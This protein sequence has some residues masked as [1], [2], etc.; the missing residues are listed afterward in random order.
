MVLFQRKLFAP[1]MILLFNFIQ[2]PWN[3]DAFYFNHRNH[4]ARSWRPSFVRQAHSEGAP[5]LSHHSAMKTRNITVSIQFYSLLGFEVEAKFRAGPARAAWLSQPGAPSSNGRLELIE[6]PSHILQE[7]E[8]SKR[9]AFDLMERQELLGWNHLAL[10]VTDSIREKQSAEDYQL[11]D[12]M[13]DLNERSKALFGKSLRVAL[14]PRQQIIGKRVY[15]LAFLYDADGGLI[16]LLHEQSE[17]EQSL[18]SGWEPWN[19]KGTEQG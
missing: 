7:P 3:I 1:V 8:G 19:G 13:Q 11:G 9:R 16:E 18:D 4:L 6:V 5:L 2:S 14:E 17:L 15:E 12:W 10:D